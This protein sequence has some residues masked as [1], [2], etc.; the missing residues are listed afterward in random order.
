MA[1]NGKKMFLHIGIPILGGTFI[2]A[3]LFAYFL[4]KNGPVSVTSLENIDGIAFP[5]VGQ[6]TVI[7][8]SFAHADI[9]LP[10][11]RLGKNLQLTLTFSPGT[12]D[13][14]GVAVRENSFWFSYHPVIFYDRLR[15]K[16]SRD[17]NIVKT[18]TI[19]LTDK[20]Q[21]TDQSLDL[22]FFAS[23]A[24]TNLNPAHV[25]V[26]DTVK[27]YISNLKAQ[28]YATQPSPQEAKQFLKRFIS[29]ER[30]V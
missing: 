12:A 10:T 25:R 20:I 29:K 24:G 7:T 3:L 6:Q 17:E 23:N 26:N 27:W 14:L 18:V 11:S 30:P 4:F 28:V 1:L 5:V 8:E 2:T 13:T 16:T 19:P 21:S 15:D 22:L 9:L